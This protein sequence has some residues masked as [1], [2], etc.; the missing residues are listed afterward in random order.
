MGWQSGGVAIKGKQ[1]DFLP[2]FFDHFRLIDLKQDE[3]TE[4]FQYVQK[5]IDQELTKQE[6]SHISHKLVWEWNGWTIIEDLE[7]IFF[8]EKEKLEQI[9]REHQ[10][11]IFT[12]LTTSTSGS[13]GFGYYDKGK[14]RF[15]FKP[16]AEEP[17]EQTGTPLAEESGFNINDEA[18]YEDIVGVARKIG[19]DFTNIE[20]AGRYLVKKLESNDELKAELEPLRE[21]YEAQFKKQQSSKPWWKFW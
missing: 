2:V 21:Q 14:A 12:Y 4:D 6:W 3:V 15:F 11:T 16:A 10:L 9:S 20:H 7:W 8:M 19:I 5:K 1:E 17:V 18:W 13:W